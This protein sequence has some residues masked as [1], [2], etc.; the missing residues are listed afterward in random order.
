MIQNNFYPTGVSSVL[1][2]ADATPFRV[3]KF[4]ESKST[5]KM[6]GSQM[7]F[8]AS[9]IIFGGT[10]GGVTARKNPKGYSS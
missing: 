2:C 5:P 9:E 10:K 6:A 3:I 8:G 4:V 1:T 7:K